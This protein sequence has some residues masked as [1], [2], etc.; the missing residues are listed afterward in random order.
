MEI[1]YMHVILR[2]L[3]IDFNSKYRSRVK[4]LRWL[5][6]LVRR[7]WD[8]SKF[9]SFLQRIQFLYFETSQ[10]FQIKKV[11]HLKIWTRDPFFELKLKGIWMIRIL[12]YLRYIPQA[13]S[14]MWQISSSYLKVPTVVL[15]EY[16][17]SMTLYWLIKLFRISYWN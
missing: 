11:S 14:I 15:N 8:S 6:F 3:K 4:I 13:Y 7:F 2:W 5:T 1:H 9:E 10:N 12:C 16:R 17:I